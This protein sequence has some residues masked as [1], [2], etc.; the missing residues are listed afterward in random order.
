MQASILLKFQQPKH[1]LAFLS[2]PFRW[3]TQKI[4]KESPFIYLSG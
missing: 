4:S 1:T 2:T 3:T